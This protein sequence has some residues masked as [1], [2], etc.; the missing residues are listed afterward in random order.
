MRIGVECQ[1]PV[2]PQ[3][4]ET[5]F[6]S[7]E[8]YVNLPEVQTSV[9]TKIALKVEMFNVFSA[10]I[11]VTHVINDDKSA[12]GIKVEQGNS[13]IAL[14]GSFFVDFHKNDNDPLLDINVSSSWKDAGNRNILCEDTLLQYSLPKV[15]VTL[16]P[17]I[18]PT[19]TMQPSKSEP[20]PQPSKSKLSLQPSKDPWRKVGKIIDS[21]NTNENCGHAVDISS[22]GKKVLL[23]CP[24]TR[25]D[26]FDKAGSVHLYELT[27]DDSGDRWENLNLGINGSEFKPY[28]G[29]SVAFASNPEIFAI[30]EG[31]GSVQIFEINGNVRSG[32]VQ[33]IG[34][35]TF[36]R[37]A[38]QST[39]DLSIDLAMGG[40]R[41]AMGSASQGGE[42]VVVDDI[43]G[44]NTIKKIYRGGTRDIY[45]TSV[46]MSE[47]GEM[48]AVSMVKSDRDKDSGLVHIYDVTNT[49]SNDP[50]ITFNTGASDFTLQKRDSPSSSISKNGKVCAQGNRL[51]GVQPGDLNGVVKFLDVETNQRRG[52]SV[53]GENPG[54]ECG[55]SVALSYDGET[56][57]IGCNGKVLIAEW[58]GNDWN[59][60]RKLNTDANSSTSQGRFLESS[61]S[62]FPVAI[63][64]SGDSLIVGSGEELGDGKSGAQVFG[65][66]SSA[67][68]PSIAPPTPSPAGPSPPNG[69]KGK[70]M[71]VSKGKGIKVSKGGKGGKGK[72]ISKSPKGNKGKGKKMDGKG[73]KKNKCKKSK[74][75]PDDYEE[76]VGRNECNVPSE[77]NA[78]KV[79][80]DVVSARGGAL[81]ETDLNEMLCN[82]T[83]P[84]SR[85]RRMRF[86][87]SLEVVSLFV[88]NVSNTTEG[89]NLSLK[90]LYHSGKV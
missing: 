49:T 50:I 19:K 36:N 52:G 69:G 13:L 8:D 20:T 59:V 60:V 82:S 18:Q 80:F 24:E 86:L 10:P 27:S 72:G 14:E 46:S 83:D 22:D 78:L 30:G 37:R 26:G 42:V 17:S 57:A 2:E 88:S 12:T 1:V 89:K 44:S 61:A 21:D 35:F 62:G 38:F 40:R 73:K 70:G 32:F 63:S 67:T 41:L 79:T 15:K 68:P 85:K 3:K 64:K 51:A 58:D 25:I 45:G 81:N 71:K 56:A 65:S 11:F 75:K 23:G 90:R 33:K 84:T 39:I 87:S 28:T 34:S 9:N 74:K 6:L 76:C 47:D 54:D 77:A 53:R 29:I 31:K 66:P 16:S 5:G 55:K 43:G 7:C 48:L 4:S